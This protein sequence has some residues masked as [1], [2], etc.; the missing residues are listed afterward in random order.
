MKI[1]TILFFTLISINTYAKKFAGVYLEPSIGYTSIN[2]DTP[3]SSEGV[4][5]E[6]EM[7]GLNINLTLGYSDAIFFTGFYAGYAHELDIDVTFVNTSGEE[8]KL[9]NT[10]T[11]RNTYGGYLLGFKLGKYARLSGYYDIANDLESFNEDG[12]SVSEGDTGY[13][14][15]GLSL[16]LRLGK[17]TYLNLNYGV[18]K[19]VEV[20]TDDYKM[21][22]VTASLSFPIG[23]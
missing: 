18:W 22:S 15:Y 17:L 7:S 13:E 12:D 6:T 16:G 4:R 19:K 14:R 1:I 20:D 3:T 8:F 21:H 5:A 10:N 2:L 9:D 11:A 23:F